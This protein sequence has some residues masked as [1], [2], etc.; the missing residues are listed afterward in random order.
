M[1]AVGLDLKPVGGVRAKILRR[2]SRG[3]A[4]CNSVVQLPRRS[5]G[6]YRSFLAFQPDASL[7]ADAPMGFQLHASCSASS[8]C[9]AKHGNPATHGERH[10]LD[11]AHAVHGADRASCSSGTAGPVLSGVAAPRRHAGHGR[12]HHPRQAV[13]RPVPGAQN[14]APSGLG[15]TW[16]H[17]WRWRAVARR[18]RTLV[19]AGSAPTGLGIATDHDFRRSIADGSLSRE[20]PLSAICSVPVVTVTEYT[21]ASAALLEMVER[22]IHHLVVTT[23]T[24]DPVGVVRVVDLASA[25]VRDP[26]L[27]RR[28]VH[29][30]RGFDDLAAAAAILP[31]RSSSW[32]RSAPLRSG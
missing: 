26:L 15:G 31:T 10:L 21:D 29:R 4:Q 6:R 30:A 8:R 27:V 28:L 17:D 16:R 3:M 20:A 24:G 12:A 18:P 5:L 14:H 25:E 2:R 22:G 9:G 19:R 32:P 13:G 7:L 11:I 23:D 1:C